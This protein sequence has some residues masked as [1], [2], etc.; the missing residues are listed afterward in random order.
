MKKN[1]NHMSTQKKKASESNHALQ[2]EMEKD[3][4][5]VGHIV[6]SDTRL[7]LLWEVGRQVGAV[8]EL[9]QL[10]EQ[11]I[12]MTQQTMKAAASSVILLDEAGRNLVFD[13]AEGAV[14]GKLSQVKMDTQSGIA[15]WVVR[16]GKPI[17]VNNV[18]DNPEWNKS[19]DK[20]TGFVTKSIICVPLIA[21][22][23]T[24]GVLEVINKLDGSGFTEQD[25]DTLVCVASTAAITIEN[26]RLQK[27]VLDAYKSTI[28][29]LAAAIDAKDPYTRGHSQR[30]VEYAL[31][32]G[33]SLSFCQDELD[34]IEY[35][36]ILHDV[37]KIGIPDRILTKP[38]KLTAEE[39]SIVRK[40]PVMSANI[41]DGV[42]FL[43]AVQGPVLHHHERYDGA[44]YPEGLNGDKIPMGAMILAVADTFDAITTNRP[45]R[46]A[47][48]IDFAIQELCKC[49]GN[50]LCPT[51]VE[52]FVPALEQSGY[53]DLDLKAR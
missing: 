18:A 5:M 35:A 15:G 1:F 53:K 30:V 26:N 12:L 24:L 8:I 36:G 33:R 2:N 47:L 22:R 23:Q 3:S 4:E 9:G 29:A 46:A 17:I 42:P 37:G 20:T 34:V 31:L 43:K 48:S 10:V 19:F 32:I 49:S 6:E 51:V 44:G 45:Y 28:K 11:I 14:G 27:S 25:L 39:Y 13:I 40:H 41:I 50:Q 52:A 21:H 38:G 7:A 16:H